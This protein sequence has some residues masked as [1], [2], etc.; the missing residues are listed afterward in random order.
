M[1]HSSYLILPFS[2]CLAVQTCPS[3]KF[4]ERKTTVNYFFQNAV[5]KRE[6]FSAFVTLMSYQIEIYYAKRS[7]YNIGLHMSE[8]IFPN[9]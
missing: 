8:I 4:N 7:V 2:E 5:T 3:S 9:I 1:V 6:K